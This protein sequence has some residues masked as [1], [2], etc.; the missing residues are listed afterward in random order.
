[1]VPARPSR[2]VPFLLALSL[3]VPAAAQS[4]VSGALQGTVTDAAGEPLPGATVTIR[5]DALVRGSATSVTD[6]SGAW[7][8]PSLP[9]GIYAIEASLSGFKP[10][11]REGVRVALGQTLA[12]PFQLALASVAADLVVTGEAPQ[13]SVVSSSVSNAV[14]AEYIERQPVSRSFAGLVNYAPG[15]NGGLAYGGTQSAT[16]AYNL[17]GVNVA[18]PASG[19]QWILPNVDWIQEVQVSGLGADA[20]HGG[21]TGASVNL[22]TKSGGNVF[23]GDVTVYYSGG[24][25]TSS[26]SS[27]PALTPFEKDKDLDVGV[28]AGGALRR[29]LL[30]FFASAQEARSEITPQGARNSEVTKLSRYL[31]KL[32]AQL[33][34]AHRIVGLLDYDGKVADRRGISDLRLESAT[35]RQDSP[36]VTYSLSWEGTL[37]PRSFVEAKATGFTGSDDRIPYGGD[38]PGR[39]DDVTGIRW[40]NHAFTNTQEKRRVT[41]DGAWSLFLDGL[42]AKGDT[43]RIKTGLSYE[44]ARADETNRRNGGFTYYDD[45]S[46]CASLGAYFTVPA[47]GL[48]SSDFGDEIF[49]KSTQRGFHAFVQDAWQIGRITVNAGLRYTRY[50][51]GFEGKDESVYSIS[52]AWAPRVGLAWDLLGDATTAAKLHVGRYYEGMFAYLYDREAS[53]GAFTPYEIRD[54]D[55]RTGQ[56]SILVRRTPNAAALDPDVQHPHVDQLVASLE[57]QVGRDVALGLDYVHRKNR[58][59]VALV[60]AN[61]D[62]E[63]QVTVPA[64]SPAGGALPP[65]GGVFPFFDLQS[66]P[67]FTLT[68]PGDAFRRYDAVTLR[69]EKRHSHG[70]SA[71]ASVVWADLRGNAFK[72]NGYVPE[73]QDANGQVNAEG[74]LPGFSRWEVKVSGSVD[75]PFGFLASAY[76]LFLS[77][78]RW[79]PFVQM[80]GLFKND[81]TN[82]FT[83]ER[84]SEKLP[85]R[86]TVDLR[87]SKS[88]DLGGRFRATLYA[89]A[90]NVF[91]S[92]TAL[93][94]DA[95]WGN[96]RYDFRNPSRS[97]FQKRSAYGRTLT[98]ERPRE[99]RLGVRFSF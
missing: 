34:E 97:T 86:S 28:T 85:D 25:L 11:T 88:F 67:V 90:F 59:I 61:D 71:R 37:S 82:V 19:E 39:Q 54:Y 89:D 95:Y 63:R 32:S 20:E 44:T 80:R 8:F 45:S 40:A 75:L 76:Y 92:D 43:H 3:A 65:G 84:G 62:Y 4:T 38:A 9:P 23:K 14:T 7:R 22:L 24:S 50:R 83:E 94:V 15:V 47:C 57:R 55:P 68:N 81:R 12:V 98:I 42:V 26:N 10:R 99:I 87:L 64:A 74:A 33:G 48:Y 36:N 13:V 16:N 66:N 93:S 56:F 27:D 78:E 60:N 1:M 21:F 18:D 6:A 49:L 30:W 41:F 29:D 53:G 73:W 51:A 52:D 72:A 91:N 58:A 79:T 17:D 69:A 96:Y 31:G 77:G 46:A 70:W 5:S 2:L 35:T